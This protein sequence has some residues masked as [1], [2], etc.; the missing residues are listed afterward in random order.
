MRPS[1]RIVHICTVP[2]YRLS[3]PRVQDAVAG[4]RGC[5]TLKS[6]RIACPGLKT[7]LK[8]SAGFEDLITVRD[9]IEF[10]RGSQKQ[11]AV[12]GGGCGEA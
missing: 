7:G 1:Y 5:P 11:F 3:S 9:A 6:T 2:R 10:A 12:G 8:K 4:M